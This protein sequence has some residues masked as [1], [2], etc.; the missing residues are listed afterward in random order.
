MIYIAFLIVGFCASIHVF[1]F[2]LWLK[3]QGNLSG[4]LL[5]LLMALVATGLPLYNVLRR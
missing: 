1:S 3:R 5:T 4:F 2:G